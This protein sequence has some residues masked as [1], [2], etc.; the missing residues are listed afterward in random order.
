MS[1]R[2]GGLLAVVVCGFLCVPSARAQAVYTAIDLGPAESIG[3]AAYGAAGGRQVGVAGGAQAALWDRS[4]AGFINL[5]PAH[6]GLVGSVATGIGG[7]QQVGYGLDAANIN[8]L[9]ALLWTGTAASAV[10]LTP[11]GW[12]VALA[13]GTDG[14]RQF[15]YGSATD[16][17]GGPESDHALMW[18]GTAAGFT[19]LNPAGMRLSRILGVGGGQQVGWGRGDATN[20]GI[21]AMLWSGTAGSAVDLAPPDVRQSEAYSAAGGQ[22]VG[23]GVPFADAQHRRHALLWRGTA[24]TVTLLQPAGFT[25]SE[26]YGTNGLQQVGYG[27]GPI[28]GGPTLANHALLWNGSPGDYVDLH[29]FLPD[30]FASSYARA[31]DENGAIAGYAFTDPSELVPSQ[32][33]ILWVPV[34][35]P[36]GLIT[37]GVLW[38]CTLIRRR[39]RL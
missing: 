11:A 21:H 33:A 12:A 37:I 13:T 22:Q 25:Q 3:N 29:S 8:R 2:S 19:D 36:S 30:Q 20:D 23:Y 38:G 14:T 31:I 24:A 34:P 16:P 5:H 39:P 7:G 9:H 6:L 1:G 26:A 28:N 18:N 15:G 35:E 27:L 32:H 4:A 10:D 17:T